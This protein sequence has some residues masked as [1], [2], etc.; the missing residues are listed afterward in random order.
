MCY[1]VGKPKGNDNPKPR[2]E[3]DMSDEEN[4]KNDFDSRSADGSGG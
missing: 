4:E 2:N 3:R 1:N